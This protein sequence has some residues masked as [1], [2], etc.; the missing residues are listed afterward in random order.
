MIVYTDLVLNTTYIPLNSFLE[1]RATCTTSNYKPENAYIFKEPN[2]KKYL[3]F[4][5]SYRIFVIFFVCFLKIW[6]SIFSR[7]FCP[8]PQSLKQFLNAFFK[9]KITIQVLGNMSCH[10]KNLIIRSSDSWHVFF[11]CILQI[12]SC[13]ISSLRRLILFWFKT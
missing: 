8:F 4:Q 10:K 5:A 2:S 9:Y 7:L 1:Y 13:Q 6:N 3:F 11:F 12:K